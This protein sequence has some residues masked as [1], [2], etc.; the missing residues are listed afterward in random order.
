MPSIIRA[1]GEELS[2]HL[3][4]VLP[5]ADSLQRGGTYW[6]VG[7]VGIFS[8]K[9]NRGKTAAIY[10]L[11]KKLLQTKYFKGFQA[12]TRDDLQGIPYGCS[13]LQGSTERWEMER[14]PFFPVPGWEGRALPGHGRG[15]ELP[16]SPS[17]GSASPAPPWRQGAQAGS[18]SSPQTIYL[19]RSL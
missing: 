15:W 2:K 3:G 19:R 1:A 8:A 7:K 14:A 18:P 6:A 5:A 10:T 12:A 13:S 11:K 17:A 16:C 9:K 4:A